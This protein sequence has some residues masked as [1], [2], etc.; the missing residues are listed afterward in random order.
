MYYHACMNIY[1]SRCHESIVMMKF[2]YDFHVLS[3]VRMF[4][5]LISDQI[6]MSLCMNV[7]ALMTTCKTG[8]ELVA[9]WISFVCCSICM[10]TH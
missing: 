10:Y 9:V 8:H 4:M 3:Y 1:V 7:Y 6:C 2:V 5:K